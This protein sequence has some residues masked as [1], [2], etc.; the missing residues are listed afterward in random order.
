MANETATSAPV[1]TPTLA[2]HRVS[3]G[4]RRRD[5]PC[6]AL[7]GCLATIGA[8]EVETL[9]HDGRRSSRRSPLRIPASSCSTCTS[10]T[11]TASASSGRTAARRPGLA[12]RGESCSSPATSARRWRPARVALGASRG[13]D[14]AVRPRRPQGHPGPHP[15]RPG[16][17]FGR[18][19][20]LGGQ[21]R[22]EP[23]RG[24]LPDAVRGEPGCLPRP[25]S[26]FRDRGR[27]RRCTCAETMTAGDA[28]V[29][30]HIFDV[31]PDNPG[32][33]ERER[34]RPSSAP[35]SSGCVRRRA[36]DTM[37]VQQYDIR[38]PDGE[39]RG[40]LLEPREHAGA[41]RARRAP[42]R[43]PPRRGR[44]RLR[45]RWAIGP[46]RLS[47]SRTDDTTPW[48]GSWCSARASC[49]G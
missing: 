31:F 9:G 20:P 48:L 12:R 32:D 15:R 10:A 25:R 27:D 39:V 13:P 3:G 7:A 1:T 14:Q 49:A 37:A 29:G 46:T 2:V 38:R 36:P 6:A 35:L 42:L 17:D 24:D 11:A 23:A 26:R 44:H 30:R 34:C 8:T 45:R 33:P 19:R 5:E 47:G 43:D 41:R 28:I 18:R 16:A 22:H 4:R 21:R 40:P